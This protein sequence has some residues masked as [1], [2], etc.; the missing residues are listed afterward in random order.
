MVEPTPLGPCIRLV[1]D[2]MKE[3]KDREEEEER[4]RLLAMQAANKKSASVIS[5]SPR[6]SDKG[7]TERE[8][9]PTNDP[10]VKIFSDEPLS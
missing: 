1:A 7:E 8:E 4:L 3:R 9:R 6:C 10:P 2:S 5:A